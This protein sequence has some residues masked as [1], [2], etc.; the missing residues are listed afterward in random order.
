MQRIRVKA[1]IRG[2]AF[3]VGSVESRRMVT[4]RHEILDRQ[5]FAGDAYITWER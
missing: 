4:Y 1:G 5:A 2:K 3:N